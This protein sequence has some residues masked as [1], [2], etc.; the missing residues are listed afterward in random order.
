V[1]I[2]DCDGVN[3]GDLPPGRGNTPFA[4]YLAAIRETGF[5]GTVSLELEFPPD[6]AAMLSWV[7]EAYTTTRKLLVDAGVYGPA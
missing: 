6:P 3:H 2:S 1:H 5:G 7:E 4:E